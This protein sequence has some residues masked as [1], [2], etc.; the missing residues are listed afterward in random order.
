MCT[1]QRS[2]PREQGRPQQPP[3]EARRHVNWRAGFLCRFQ[4]VSSLRCI[5]LR[6]KDL[7]ITW[8]PQSYGLATLRSAG[9]VPAGE[10]P[11]CLVNPRAVTISH[12]SPCR[13][14]N[15]PDVLQVLSPALTK[16]RE[17]FQDLNCDPLS[18]LQSRESQDC[19]CWQS[20]CRTSGAETRSFHVDSLDYTRV[21]ES[22]A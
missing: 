6:Q 16:H 5:D 20:T 13:A 14:R 1:V 3:R 22:S 7:S 18:T 2:Q 12:E 9:R 4:N 10:R 15:A 19:E 8:S 11:Y 21:S 17:N